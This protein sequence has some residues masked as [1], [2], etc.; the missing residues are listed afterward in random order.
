MHVGRVTYAIHRIE[1]LGCCLFLV[2]PVITVMKFCH[3]CRDKQ[4]FGVVP[5]TFPDPV[6]RVHSALIIGRSR[7]QV[8]ARCGLPRTQ[9]R[10]VTDNGRQL[11]P[12][13]PGLRP[14]PAQYW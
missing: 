2:D 10:Q 14:F 12:D 6:T 11:R 4:A 7:T 1:A 8:G 9:P 3:V 13:H 5:G